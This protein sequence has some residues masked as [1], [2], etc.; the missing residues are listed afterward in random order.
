MLVGFDDDVSALDAGSH[1]RAAGQDL[2]DD[3]AF[4]LTAFEKSRQLG[5]EILGLHAQ[6][7][8]GLLGAGGLDRYALGAGEHLGGR[9]DRCLHP[10]RDRDGV[11]RAAVHLQVF[12]FGFQR[13]KGDERVVAQLGDHGP[14]ELCVQRLQEIAD[15]IVGERTREFDV[16][17][18]DRDRPRLG[19]GDPD[20]QQL[21]VG[22]GFQDDHRRLSG[23]IDHQGFHLGFDQRRI[24]RRVGRSDHEWQ[25]DEPT[26]TFSGHR[27][28]RAFPAGSVDPSRIIGRLKI[29]SMAELALTGAERL[30]MVV[31]VS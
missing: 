7:C 3:H 1:R 27:N 26:P 2:G 5:G 28:L 17:Q 11:A 22:H 18:R 20:R 8:L 16:F 9:E 31:R 14:L 30:S 29:L 13:Q 15:Q 12:S 4:L 23:G 24:L 25:Q 21:F 19:G 10:E 6:A